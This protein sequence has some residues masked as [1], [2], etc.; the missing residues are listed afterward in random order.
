MIMVTA[1]TLM[2]Y[3]LPRADQNS[4]FYHSDA[5]PTTSSTAVSTLHPLYFDARTTSSSQLE[6]CMILESIVKVVTDSTGIACHPC[7][8]MHTFLQAYSRT[9]GNDW[10]MLTLF[11]IIGTLNKTMQLQVS[12]EL[13][14]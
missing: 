10:Q 7:F 3:V 11:G 5:L 12:Y 4:C 9:A 2:N 13:S 6:E 8:I 14:T 1:G